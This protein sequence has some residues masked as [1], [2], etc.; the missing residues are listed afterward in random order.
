MSQ[1]ARRVGKRLIGRY[2]FLRIILG[3]AAL[4]ST[5]I[6]AVF[7]AKGLVVD[8]SLPRYNA[9]MLY[10]LTLN[11][12]SFGAISITFSARFSRKSAF[13]LRSFRGNRLAWW[14]YTIMTVLQ[15]FITYC[16]GVN[17]VIFSMEGMVS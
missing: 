11:T 3:T 12:L 6:G 14:S 4:V 8:G 13:H 17:R 9:G 2:L 15:V 16:P 5:T 10:S 1:P 7:W